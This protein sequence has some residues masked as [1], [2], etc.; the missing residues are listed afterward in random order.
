[1]E[2]LPSYLNLI[3]QY[4]FGVQPNLSRTEF[5][6]GYTKQTRTTTKLRSVHN[7]SYYVRSKDEFLSFKEWHKSK[8]NHGAAYFIWTNPKTNADQLARMVD[9]SYQAEP[10]SNNENVYVE[11]LIGLWEIKFNIEVYE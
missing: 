2:R 8:I 1:M 4:S 6:D 9:G 3:D 11:P 7:L 10:L 5:E